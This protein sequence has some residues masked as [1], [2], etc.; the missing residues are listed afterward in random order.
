MLEKNR[1]EMKDVTL[2]PVLSTTPAMQPVREGNTVTEVLY[3]FDKIYKDSHERRTRSYD[4]KL[5]EDA[6][7]IPKI[8]ASSKKLAARHRRGQ[9]SVSTITMSEVGDD[10]ES[11]QNGDEIGVGRSSERTLPSDEYC[12]DSPV[13]NVDQLAGYLPAVT[14][15]FS[16]GKSATTSI[17]F[18]AT[19]PMHK[20][21][22]GDDH[23]SVETRGVF[24]PEENQSYNSNVFLRDRGHEQAMPSNSERKTG[25]ESGVGRGAI[26]RKELPPSHDDFI[27]HCPAGV[28]MRAPGAAPQRNT[29]ATMTPSETGDS[30][31]ASTDSNI[32]RFDAILKREVGAFST[33]S[34]QYPHIVAGATLL[35]D[36]IQPPS[37][38]SQ[39]RL[40]SRTS[41]KDRHTERLRGRS[42][43]TS[44]TVIPKSV[45]RCCLNMVSID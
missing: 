17:I 30:S 16:G 8:N 31:G 28:R 25:P 21:T 43:S 20:G 34:Q 10:M 35:R 4:K 7:F 2:K 15:P 11:F 27:K 23:F 12:Y 14:C 32:R 42:R 3:N 41:L 38:S 18:T 37:R 44:P 26:Q 6:Y 9:L 29:G 19:S 22:E 39:S 1:A 45:A 40:S 13:E 24:T 5:A 33:S 36:R